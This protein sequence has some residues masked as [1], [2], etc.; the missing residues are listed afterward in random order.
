MT[1]SIEK[2]LC[3]IESRNR[4]VELDKKWETSWTRRIS[5]TALTYAVVACYLLAI[6]NNKPFVN[7]CVPA[8][9]FL[10]STLVLNNIRSTWQKK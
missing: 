7:A 2:R 1:D 9:G 5:I 10:L 3:V 8:I 4:R 6:G